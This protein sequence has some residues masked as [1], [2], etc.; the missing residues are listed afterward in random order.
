MPKI[1]LILSGCGVFDGSEIH[2]S[3][4]ALVHLSRHGATVSCFAPDIDQARV[5]NHLS[6]KPAPAEKRNVL[7]E[8]ARIARGKISPLSNLNAADFDAAVFPG[9]FGAAT[10]LCD[11]ATRGADCTVNPEVARVVKQFHDA[12]KPVGMCCIAPVIGARVLGTKSGGPGVTVTIGSDAATAAAI[13]AMGSKNISKPVT[14]SYTDPKHN[15]ITTPA[16]M[17]GNAPIHQV[18]DG[19]GAMIDGVLAR[20]GAG[21]R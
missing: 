6:G 3:V 21:V 9:G 5:V 11:F 15:M 18:F 17:Y 16:Y 14:E 4:S 13:T 7:V 12:G 20:I 19:I 1:A 8:S 10:N 2:E